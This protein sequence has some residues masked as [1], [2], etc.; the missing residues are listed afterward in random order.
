MFS[1]LLS[2]GIIYLIGG[3]LATSSGWWYTSMNKD[4]IYH[5]IFIYL[6]RCVLLALS[7]LFLSLHIGTFMFLYSSGSIT[8]AAAAAVQETSDFNQGLVGMYKCS[9]VEDPKPLTPQSPCYNQV[10]IILH[11]LSHLP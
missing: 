8:S 7:P 11:Y 4:R 3:Q 2:F 9:L 5:P 1:N 10:S 6:I